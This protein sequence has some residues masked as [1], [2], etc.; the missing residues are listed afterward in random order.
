MITSTKINEDSFEKFRLDIIREH[1]ATLVKETGLD[2]AKAKAKAEK[3][4]IS[5][6]PIEGPHQL[7]NIV[8]GSGETVGG[9]WYKE[10][11]REGQKVIF[12]CFLYIDRKFRRKGFAEAALNDLQRRS[13]RLEP[14]TFDLSVS[15]LNPPAVRLYKKCGFQVTSLFMRKKRNSYAEL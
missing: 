10:I 5:E 9:L 4:I 7:E 14:C 2:S 8:A 1:A 15:N 12:I 6:L 3:E 11:R 13:S